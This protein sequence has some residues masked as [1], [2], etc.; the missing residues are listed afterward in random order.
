MNGNGRIENLVC[1]EKLATYCGQVWGCEVEPQAAAYFVRLMA[2][3][4][5]GFTPYLG[6]R[7]VVKLNHVYHAA[8]RY[9]D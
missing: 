6:T 7:K 5:A 2:R 8:A 1:A 9:F 4:I 3:Q